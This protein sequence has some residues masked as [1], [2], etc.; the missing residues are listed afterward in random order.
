MPDS[1]PSIT[2]RVRAA[3]EIDLWRTDVSGA[4]AAHRA[5]INVSRVIALVVD[6]F[7]RHHLTTRAAAL[8]FTTVF[9]LVPT[10]AVAFAMF[11]AFGGIDDA[12]EILLPRIVDYLAVGVRDQVSA[13]IDEMLGTIHGGAIGAVGSLFM[14][15]AVISLLSSIEDTFNEIWGAKKMRSLFQRVPMYV[16][17]VMLTPVMLIGGL[18][19]P[20]MVRSLAPVDWA[21]SHA[22][23]LQ[24]L[25]ARLLPLFLVCVGF[26]LLYAF[27]TSARVRVRSAAL[28]GLVGGSL[29][30]A[31]VT[32]YAAYAGQSAFYSTVY[33]PLAAI[34]VFLFWLYVSWVIVLVGAQVACASENVATYRDAVMA[35]DVGTAQRELL[36]LGIAAHVAAPFTRGEPPPSRADLQA[37]LGTSARLVNEIVDELIDKGFLHES[38]DRSTVYPAR[39]PRVVTAAE[40]IAALHGEAGID[41]PGGAGLGPVAEL[42]ARADDAAAAAWNGTTCA[43]LGAALSP[44]LPAR[45]D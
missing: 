36:A 29:W 23:P 44:K 16:T 21:L 1:Q 26:A 6:G 2:E 45:V 40:I 18:S 19:L 12:K 28:G 27:M 11:N 39:D 41:G 10:L 37:A 33:G 32:G 15:G 20:R 17:V 43:D 22:G 42:H 24:L 7:G 14:L 8:T 30:S 34:P 31:A 25:I 35:S 3:L 38:D 13:R 9:G 4:T 5:A